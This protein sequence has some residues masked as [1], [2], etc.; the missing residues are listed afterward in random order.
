MKK[1]IYYSSSDGKTKLHGLIWAPECEP[2]A[3][4]QIAHGMVE[5]MERY[6]GFAEF[7]NEHGILVAGN[8]HL[9]HGYSYTDEKIKDIFRKKKGISVLCRTCIE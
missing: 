6:E 9:G 2:R 7:L 8:D 3:I 5:Y 4:V 1:H